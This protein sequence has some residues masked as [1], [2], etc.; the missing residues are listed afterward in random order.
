M[1]CYEGMVESRIMAYMRAG[2]SEECGVVAMRRLILLGL[3]AAMA[4]PAGAARHVTVAQLEKMLAA[5]D[6]KHREGT[7]LVRQLGDIELTQRLTDVARDRICANLHLGPQATLALQLVADQSAF[8]DPPAGEL[9]A[10][11]KPDDATAQRILDA[12]RSYVTKTLPH[13]PDFFATRTTYSFDDSPQV[14]KKDEWPVRAGLHLV[15]NSSREISVRGDH[16]LP[17]AAPQSAKSAPTAP[18]TAKEPGLQSWGEFGSV[19]AVIFVDTEKVRPSFHHWERE[20]GGVVAVY[21]YTVA[22]SDSHYSVDYCCISDGSRGNGRQGGGRRGGSAQQTN[23][24]GDGSS[25]FHK[26]PGYRGS[27]FIDPSSGAILR[28]TLEAIMDDIPIPR[29]ATLIDY[30]PVVI[31]ER[32]YICPLRSM[33]LTQALANANSTAP[34]HPMSPDEQPNEIMQVNETTFT[35]YHRL[36]STVRILSDAEAAPASHPEA[37]PASHP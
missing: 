29:V 2:R 36:G 4:L 21:R 32:R 15:G 28:I 12:A 34:M 8:L 18:A 25:V 22:K 17:A 9:P 27:L 37:A 23:S 16:A 14:F 30:G 11:A 31:G 1:R 5:A 7:E 33:T 24:P 35:N 6:V 19:L 10:N 3:L 20:P 13:L 26:T